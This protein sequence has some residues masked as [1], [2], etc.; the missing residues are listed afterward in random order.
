MGISVT[1]A[2]DTGGVRG[3]CWEFFPWTITT[4]WAARLG[5]FKGPRRVRR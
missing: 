5:M 1:R 4:L 3:L 2:A